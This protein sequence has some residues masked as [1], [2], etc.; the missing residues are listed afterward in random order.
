MSTK[1]TKSTM[2]TEPPTPLTVLLQTASQWVMQSLLA[3]LHRSGYDAISEPHLILFGNLDCGT[4]HASAIAQRIGVS[5]QAIYRTVRELQDLGMLCLETDPVRGNQ[6]VVV[7][8]ERGMQLATDARAALSRVEDI[9]GQRVG[10]GNARQL[11][12]ALEGNWGAVI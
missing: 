1:F 12:A 7:M 8:T 9:L 4:T 10:H 5:R 11:R 2:R 6:K 3:E